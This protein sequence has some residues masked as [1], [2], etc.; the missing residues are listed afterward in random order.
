MNT[1]VMVGSAEGKSAAV[2]IVGID[3]VRDPDLRI[4][5]SVFQALLLRLAVP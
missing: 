1:Y 2:V 4:R 5:A 3:P